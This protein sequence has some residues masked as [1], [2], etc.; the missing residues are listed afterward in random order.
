MKHRK[1]LTI[2]FSGLVVAAGL[3][4]GAIAIAGGSA[5]K[6]NAPQARPVIL[7]QQG[8]QADDGESN[9][10]GTD[11]DRAKE[12]ALRAT[13]GGR[14]NAVERDSEDG[15]TWEVEVTKRDGSTVDVRLDEN[16]DVVVIEPDSEA[17]GDGR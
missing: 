3:S 6:P 5:S 15:A 13:G 1:G 12:A 10:S 16:Y 11:A 4:V 7:A 9:V 14:A 8:S 17:P 2:G